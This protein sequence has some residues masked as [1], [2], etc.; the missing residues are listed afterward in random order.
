MTDVETDFD[1][2]ASE[3]KPRKSRKRNEERD[4]FV[5]QIIDG[6][7]KKQGSFPETVIGAPLERRLPMFLKDFFG[8]GE[9]RTDIRKPNGQF[10]TSF[11]FSIATEPE[12]ADRE[13]E[14]IIDDE[15]EDFD[16]EPEE[17]SFNGNA[18]QMNAVEVENLLL[19]ER[20]RRFEDELS[21]QKTGNQSEMQTLISALEESR[22]EQRELMMMMLS[23]SQKPQQDATTQAMNLLEKSFGMVTKAR[24]ISDELAPPETNSN[25]SFLGDAAKL[26]DSLGKNAGT[27]LPM[28]L[29]RSTPSVKPATARKV[30]KPSAATN[31]NGNGQG[32]LSDLLGKVKN[33]KEGAK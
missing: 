18:G 13:R 6:K 31:G 32:E 3:K 22:R 16:D 17:F 19:K 7:A 15:Q 5:Y 29:N 28:F 27:F 30:S 14:N 23:Q 12:R 21:R 33:K 2:S 26:V 11:D 9:F 10:E 1:E 25:G 8:E 4:I 24:A 20:L